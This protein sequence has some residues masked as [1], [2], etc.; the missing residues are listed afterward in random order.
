MCVFLMEGS[1]QIFINH[2]SVLALEICVVFILH[3]NY[4]DLSYI[5]I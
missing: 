1:L 2:F 3:M 5:T 4:P